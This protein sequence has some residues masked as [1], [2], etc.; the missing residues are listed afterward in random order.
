MNGSFGN[1][2]MA[3]VS[4]HIFGG[5]NGLDTIYLEKLGRLLLFSWFF[6]LGLI[7]N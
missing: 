5:L 4:V 3:L 7:S 6:Y 1:G 2:K